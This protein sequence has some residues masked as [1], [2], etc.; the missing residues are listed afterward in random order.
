MMADHRW[1]AGIS[2]RALGRGVREKQMD[3]P[4]A[5]DRSEETRRALAD[6]LR[7]LRTDGF[8]HRP[9]NRK[10]LGRLLGE[11]MKRPA[12]A[13]AARRVG[14][15]E[16]PQAKSPPPIEALLGYAH[17]F[18]R[19]TL[20]P[21]GS[22]PSPDEREKMRPL[23]NELLALRDGIRTPTPTAPPPSGPRPPAGPATAAPDRS[24]PVRR[25]VVIAGVAAIAALLIGAGVIVVS[26]RTAKPAR[27]TFC[28]RN[29]DV[30]PAAGGVGVVC[31]RDILLRPFPAAPSDQGVG[32]VQSGARF[33]VDR[34]T[35]S[36]TWVHGTAR[37]KDGKDAAGWIEAGWFCP[38]ER[39]SNPATVCA[40][41]TP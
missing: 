33:L 24:K 17:L 5:S 4:S 1:F 9:L 41:V 34:Y 11:V 2:D 39:T 20:P 8:Q 7:E 40:A 15:F 32:T 23:E 35:P 37:L 29:T 21:Y 28:A 26:G 3:A 22:E 6:R 10:E 19:S 25:P 36:G 13:Y 16:N 12:G 30:R 14:D 27:P 31:A 18:G 38:P